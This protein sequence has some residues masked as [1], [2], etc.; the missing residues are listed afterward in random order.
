M[1]RIMSV[2]VSLSRNTEKNTEIL[3]R[4]CYKANK[5]KQVKQ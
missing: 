5:N 4:W 2:L 3:L 1:V